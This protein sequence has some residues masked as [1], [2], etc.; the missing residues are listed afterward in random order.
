M[1]ILAAFLLVLP[2]LGQDPAALLE[3]KLMERLRQIDQRFGEMVD[4]ACEERGLIVRPLLNSCVFS[5]PLIIT[6]D[7]I[8]RMFD[9][10]DEA[11]EEVQGAML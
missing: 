3:A 1:R 10:L 2:L 4:A 9:I 11:V 8:D 6:H 5:P 7:E